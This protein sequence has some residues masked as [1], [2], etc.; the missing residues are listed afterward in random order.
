MI[1]KESLRKLVKDQRLDIESSEPGISREIG[2][3]IDLTIPFAR[4]ISGIRRCG[5]STLLRQLL[6]KLPDYY[7]LNF[8]DTRLLSFETSDF[9]KLKEVFREEFGN[10]D[11]YLFDEIQNIQDWEIFVRTE[12][13]KGKRFLIT[14]SNASLLSSE[15]G[16]RL[17]GRHLNTEL[18]PFSYAEALSIMKGE[19]EQLSYQ[20][21]LLNGGFP[22]YIKY[23]K[24][25]ILRELLSDIIQRD[26]VARYGINSSRVLFEM[27]IYLLTNSGKE[28]TFNGL[29]KIFS[30]GS[31][32]TAISFVSYL[33]N[34]YLLFSISKFDFSLKKQLINPKKIY[35]IDNGLSVANS[36]SL[37]P[38]FG[39]LLENA[40]FLQLRRNQKEIYYFKG[41]GE[42]DFLVKEKNRII[43]AIQV[44]YYFTDDN[45][46]RKLNGLLEAMNRFDLKEGILLT[47]NQEDQ[48]RVEGKIIHIKPVW[49]WSME[50]SIF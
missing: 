7:Y 21:Y 14:G 46:K 29:K 44:T 49:K 20:N 47:F 25:E 42:C 2:N 19:A 8:E 33:E 41:E 16:T 40:V 28:F 36:S 5:K 9:E 35:S 48:L 30:L 17:T 15:L 6:A 45:R 3:S 31:V 10:S 32:N 1:L 39:R 38:D 22:E 23:G 18:F 50:N 24:S 11:I 43:M 13:D 4:I 26:I 12:L 27:A 37:S 34:S